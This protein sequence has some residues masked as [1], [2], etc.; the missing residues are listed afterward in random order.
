MAGV[1][2][3]TALSTVVVEWGF[4]DRGGSASNKANLEE[5][6]LE[7][8]SVEGA[9]SLERGRL[10]SKRTKR[11]GERER[12]REREREKRERE[13]EREREDRRTLERGIY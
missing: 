11:E 12:E 4:T 7:G 8:V 13:R 9:G 1:P 3:A 6:S 2:V 10:A 5:G